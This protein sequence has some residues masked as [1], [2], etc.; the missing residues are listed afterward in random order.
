VHDYN[1]AIKYKLVHRLEVWDCAWVITRSN[2]TLVIGIISYHLH[3]GCL[4]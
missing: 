2:P 3:A 4:Q 1:Q